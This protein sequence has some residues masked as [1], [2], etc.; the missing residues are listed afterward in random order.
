MS[1]G[2]GA[3]DVA[4]MSPCYWPEVRRGSER[5]L[6]E[7]SA[8]LLAR[9]HRPRLITSHPGLPTWRVE[10]GMPIVRHWRPPEGWLER[11][12]FD[13]YLTHAPLSYAAL[14]LGRRADVAHAIHPTDALVA[15]RWARRT[16]RPAVFSFMGIPDRA[17]IVGE[18][19]GPRIVARALAR[20]SAVVALSAA[21]AAAFRQTVGVDAQVIHPGVDLATFRPGPPRNEA[22]TVFCAAALAEPRKRVALLV[23]AFRLVRRER[24]DARLVLSRPRHPDAARAVGAHGPGIELR[25]VDDRAELARA[26]AQA[27]VSALPSV[28]EAFGLVLLEAMA[29][30]TPGVGSNRDGI[31]EVISGP[32]LGRLFE[33]DNEWMLARAILEALELAQDPATAPA[34]R[35]HAETFSAERCT[36][37]YLDLYRGLL[38]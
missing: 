8:G 24:P 35:A 28:G 34:C 10:E 15:A 23:R 36:E 32:Q 12:S 16:G 31:P 20:S 13:P 26:Y 25:D 5:F 3:L 17:A 33:G 27:W 29:C 21:A 38:G 11:R 19:L 2:A 7:L 30:G 22:P 4:L 18:R 1:A 6:H 37:R 14:R 9:G